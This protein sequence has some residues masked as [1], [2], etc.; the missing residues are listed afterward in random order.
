MEKVL[1]EWS[2]GAIDTIEPVPNGRG[3]LSLV[4]ASEGDSFVLKKESG[5][6]R[7]ESGYALLRNLS[8]AGV[9]VP[10]PVVTS[11][12]GWYA[13]GEQGGRFCL[14]PRL[15][16]Q[17]VSEHYTGDAQG[18]ARAFGAAI[19]LLHVALRE[20]GNLSGFD[21]MDLVTHIA[22]WALPCIRS[23]GDVVDACAMER[24][25]SDAGGE[26]ALLQN[27]LPIQLIHRDAHTTNMLFDGGKLTGFLDFEMVRIG[28][29]AFDLCY[30]GSSILV[31]GFDDTEMAAKWPV[32]FRSLLSGYEAYCPLNP[33][34]HRALYRILVAIQLM[35]IA[36]WLDT[37]AEDA[38]QSNER[39][40]YWIA[41]N[42]AALAIR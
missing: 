40:L 30:C 27:G 6:V 3:R 10:V 11:G 41:T 16:G 9:P 28:P 33:S 25:W 20:C 39:M 18:R 37:R 14:Y 19:G 4:K 2:I 42:K 24:V 32:L 8:Q 17:V 12:G 1:E 7:S 29:R 35:F 23:G 38:A 5:L 22:E 21:E 13:V 26:L 34:E 15:P 31:D 36:W